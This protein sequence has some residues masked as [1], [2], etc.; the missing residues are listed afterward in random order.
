MSSIRHASR[1]D[2]FVALEK[3][4]LEGAKIFQITD[5]GGKESLS[6]SRLPTSCYGNLPATSGFTPPATS[7][8]A[9]IASSTSSS[10]ISPSTVL[11]TPEEPA[12]TSSAIATEP[13]NKPMNHSGTIVRILRSLPL[14]PESSTPSSSPSPNVSR[15]F[16][17]PATTSP[18]A[19]LAFSCDL[20]AWKAFLMKF[21]SCLERLVISDGAR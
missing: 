6:K 4:D 12:P 17:L 16:A 5:L 14:P 20:A 2:P 9:G 19:W 15:V 7:S 18:R 13:W 8:L 10:M 21:F 1:T 11:L 3:G